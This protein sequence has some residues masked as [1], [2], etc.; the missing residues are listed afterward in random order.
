MD[1]TFPSSQERIRHSVNYRNGSFQN[2]S[3]T[4][5]MLKSSSMWMIFKDFLNKPKTVSPSTTIPSVK[6][7]LFS[8]NSEP[9]VIWFGHSSYFIRMA[10]MNLLADPVFSGHASPFSNMIRSFKGSDVYTIDDLPPL[11]I[12]LITHDHYDHLDY[13]AIGKLQS[14]TRLFYTGLGVGRHLRNWGVD[15]DK[16][17][18]LDWWETSREKDLQIISTP[19]RHFSGRGLVR[20]K[21]LWTSFVLVSNTHRLYVGGDSGYDHHFR[22][23]GEKFGPFDLVMLDCGQYGSNWPLIHMRPEET[24]KAAKDLKAKLLLPVHWGKFALANH[25]WNEPVDRVV[26][27]AADE[28]MPVTTP[29]IGEPVIPGQSHPTREWWMSATNM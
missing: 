15:P 20:N 29:L 19:A 11:D 13:K 21:T 10:G 8:L 3:P 1:K 28:R 16:I 14:K 4:D 9:T 12:I 27:Y 25:P 6:T 2:L 17:V 26:K 18:E 7:D 23:I 22:E 5:V 24:V